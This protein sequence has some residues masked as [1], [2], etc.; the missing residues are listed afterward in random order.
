MWQNLNLY[1]YIAYKNIKPKS[2]INKIRRFLNW[3]T[4]QNNKAI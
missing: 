4:S 1:F 2:I 3:Q